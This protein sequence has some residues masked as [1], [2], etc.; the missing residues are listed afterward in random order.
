M[1]KKD[2]FTLKAMDAIVNSSDKLGRHNTN[3]KSHVHR[4]KKDYNRKRVKKDWRNDMD[5][6]WSFIIRKSLKV[7]RSSIVFHMK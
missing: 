4:S 1:K 5:N 7:N 3:A 6:L 2:N